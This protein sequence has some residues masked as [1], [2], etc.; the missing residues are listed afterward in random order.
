M[1][2]ELIDFGNDILDISLYQS[3]IQNF[4][5]GLK[6]D[7]CVGFKKPLFLGGEDRSENYEVY[8]LTLYWD[9]SHKIYEELKTLP[10]GVVIKSISFDD[11]LSGR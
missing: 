4:G 9:F 5:R 10:E 7:E 11:F 3:W 6:F 1:N 8:D 2:I